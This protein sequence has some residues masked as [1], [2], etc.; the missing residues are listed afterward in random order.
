MHSEQAVNCLGMSLE[1]NCE[2]ITFVK[3]SG[4]LAIPPKSE[5]NAH[6]LACSR[7]LSTSH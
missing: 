6:V 5:V 3:P 2:R 7:L 1:A 4:L